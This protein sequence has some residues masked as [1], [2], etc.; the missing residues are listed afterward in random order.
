MSEAAIINYTEDVI[1]VEQG[2]LTRCLYKVLSGSVGLFLNYGQVDEYLVGIMSAPDCFGEMTVLAGRPSPYT[3]VALKETSLLRVPESDFER[4]VRDNY[5]N[6]I[7]IMRTMA[8]NL[9]M[10]NMNMELLI[11]ELTELSRGETVDERALKRLVG[12]YG[13]AETE[14]LPPIVEEQEEGSA[15]DAVEIVDTEMYLPRR[16]SAPPITH[17]EYR[18]NLYQKQ[19][20]CPHCGKIFTSSRIFYSKLVPLADME[21]MRRYDGRVLYNDFEPI[22]YEVVTCPHCCFSAM[23][24]CFLESHILLK[25]RYAER[26]REAAASLHLNFDAER[27]FDFVCAQHYLALI[28]AQ[29]FLQT[30]RRQTTAQ[31]WQNLCWLYEDAGEAELERLAAANAAQAMIDAIELLDRHP[32]Q[33]QQRSFL[34][35]AAM[36]K[37]AGDNLHAREWA[38]KVRDE[39]S[40]NLYNDMAER[41]IFEIRE[42]LRAGT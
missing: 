41:M 39:H 27:D 20:T 19:Y 14:L 6:A 25:D 3:V 28:C 1:V 30:L 21:W 17:P 35:I 34:D 8:R 7:L 31:L 36:F 42:K 40:S 10:V 11:D 2:D 16:R 13:S 29:G 33:Q 32:S 12:Q 15:Q 9:A 5:Q 18:K 38:R 23:A 37:T 4:F 24:N 22:W 26:L